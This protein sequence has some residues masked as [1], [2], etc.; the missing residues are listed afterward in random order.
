MLAIS[1]TQ[2]NSTFERIVRDKSGVL[3]RVRFVVVEENGSLRAQIVSA[4]PI[5]LQNET[6][7]CL[8]I[9]VTTPKAVYSYKPSFSSKFFATE[10][11]EFY[12]SQPTRAPSHR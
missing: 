9:S 2:L 3:L 4:E 12:M 7:V 11:L 5:L 10:T 8:P 6:P 1:N